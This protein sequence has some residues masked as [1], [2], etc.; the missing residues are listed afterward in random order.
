[1]IDWDV[2]PA[3]N[4]DLVPCFVFMNLRSEKRLRRF[5]GKRRVWDFFSVLTVRKI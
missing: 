1:M 5:L 4:E 3:R 2:P